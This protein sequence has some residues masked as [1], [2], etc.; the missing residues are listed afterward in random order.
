LVA[1]GWLQPKSVLASIK[2]R[3]SSFIEEK[4]MNE[5]AIAVFIPIVAIVFGIGI[6]AIG[7]WT[8][9]RRRT[10]LL[11]N[12]HRERMAALEKGVPLP[13]LPAA[14][15]TGLVNGKRNQHTVA[16]A[17][18]SG[19]MLVGVG[20]ILAFALARIA[21]EDVALF[22]LLPAAVGLANLLFA[23]MLWRKERGQPN[24]GAG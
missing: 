14:L 13:E 19:V 4:L 17:I 11:D 16:G 6:A 15:V 22:G 20:I 23:Y 10:Q 24:G 2:P 18:R 7:I 21:G 3:D 1:S 5:D 8:D 9:H 12:A